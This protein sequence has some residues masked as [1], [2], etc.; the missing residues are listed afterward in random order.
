MIIDLILD[1]KDGCTYTP[2][3]FYSDCM[4]YGEIGFNITRAMDSDNELKTK[5]A[6][7]DYIL[8]QGYNT[9]IMDYINSQKWL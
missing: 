2:E 6:L 1:R 3:Q 4:C 8:K 9:S 5:M 7:C